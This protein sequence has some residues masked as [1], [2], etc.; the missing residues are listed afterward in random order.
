LSEG[1]FVIV[2]KISACHHPLL[3]DLPRRLATEYDDPAKQ[4]LTEFSFAYSRKII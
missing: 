1:N 4:I 2:V 3:L